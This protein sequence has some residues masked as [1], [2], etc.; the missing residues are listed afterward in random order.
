MQLGTNAVRPPSH[1]R[2]GCSRMKL[3]KASASA[4]SA[5]VRSP[6]A[7][8]ACGTACDGARRRRV[9]SDSAARRRQDH[10][11]HQGRPAVPRP[12]RPRDGAL[13]LRRRDRHDVATDLG[14][15]AE[16]TSSG[17]RRL[18]APTRDHD[19]QGRRRLLRR[20][21]HDQRRAQEAGRLRRPV[22]PGRTRTSWSARTRTPSPRPED[23][24]DKKVCSIVG[25]TPRQN[26]KESSRPRRDLAG[27][28]RATRSACTG[29]ENKAST[30]SPP[31]TRS[32]GLRRAEAPGQAQGRRLKPFNENYGIGLKKGD[33]TLQAK[34]NKALEKMVKDGACKRPYEDP[35][36]GQLQE[37]SRRRRR[38]RVHRQLKR[39]DRAR[40]RRPADA[41]RVAAHMPLTAD[42]EA[43]GASCS[44][45]LTEY[46][47]GGFWAR[48]SSPCHSAIGRPGLGHAARRR[49]GSAPC[50]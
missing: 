5:A 19:R 32:S 26:V 48:C 15:D 34:I 28:R 13:R 40:S 6:C 4:R 44:T 35:R 33:T 29:L 24:K 38:S 22:L 1:R 50:R 31:T 49:S 27:V 25:S 10:H 46:D 8:A 47:R 18:R 11:R 30:P 2:E 43:P 12:R 3:R 37:P 17:R 42:A 20:H 23:L 14:F 21:L 45:F 41:A 36:P 39:G 7:A 16:Q 9:D